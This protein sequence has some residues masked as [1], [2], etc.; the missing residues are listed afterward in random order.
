M[1]R[2]NILHHCLLERLVTVASSSGSKEEVSKK[3]NKLDQEGEAC[4]KHAK[5]KC[6]QLG[7]DSILPRSIAMDSPVPSLQV[8][9]AMACREDKK[10]GEP[11][12]H[13]PAVP[14]QRPIPALGQ[15]HQAAPGAWG[16][17]KRS[18]IIFVSTGNAT[19]SNNSITVLKLLKNGRTK[20]LN[21]KSSRS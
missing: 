14:D 15:R 11:E 13:C 8:P 20:L 21:I 17:T 12:T 10:L 4:M 7:K 19:A 18:A 16:Y 3:L 5:K 6:C 9:L 2:W 1:L